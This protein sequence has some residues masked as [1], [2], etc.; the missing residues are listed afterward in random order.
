VRAQSPTSSTQRALWGRGRSLAG[1]C[2]GGSGTGC[3]PAES[4]EHHALAAQLPPHPLR[5]EP[6]Q[7]GRGRGRGRGQGAGGRGQGAGGRGQ[8]AGAR[9]WAREQALSLQRGPRW[10]CTHEPRQSLHPEPATLVALNLRAAGRL[11]AYRGSVQ[12]SGCQRKRMKS[13]SLRPS[14][15]APGSR[16]MPAWHDPTGQRGYEGW[17]TQ[18]PVHRHRTWRSGAAGGRRQH[19]VIAEQ[20]GAHLPLR[21]CGRFSPASFDELGCLA[22]AYVVLL[23]LASSLLL[24]LFLLLLVPLLLSPA[25][26]PAPQPQ[27]EASRGRRHFQALD[28][29]SQPTEAREP[30][31][32]RG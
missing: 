4:Q 32:L 18:R 29:R 11:L 14:C 27:R 13:E 22:P 21:L 10:R 3:A 26:G 1:A 23:P 28:G 2:R 6:A 16:F 20:L 17:Y 30:A 8:G 24:H 7:Q 9:R 12:P 15:A 31:L 19:V 5:V 25:P